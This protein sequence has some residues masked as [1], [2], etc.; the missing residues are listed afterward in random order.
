MAVKN[1]TIE[2]L[3]KTVTTTALGQEKQEWICER[4][5]LACVSLATGRLYYEAAR[6]NEQDTVLFRTAY[7]KWMDELNKVDWRI[8]YKGTVYRIKQLA[9]V[10]ERNQE[11]QFRG[12]SA[13]ND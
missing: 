5:A 6:T 11:M 7:A 10:N 12:V 1:K 8:R 9:N 2:F 13:L 4:K 3:H